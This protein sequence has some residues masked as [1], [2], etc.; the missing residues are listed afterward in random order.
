VSTTNVAITNTIAAMGRLG[1]QLPGTTFESTLTARDVCIDGPADGATRTIGFWRTHLSFLRQVLNTRPLPAAAVNG[2]SPL[3]VASDKVPFTNG[4]L[5]LSTSGKFT[6]GSVADVM[7]VFWSSTAQNSTGKK[8]TTIIC[9]ARITT[10]KQLLGAILNQSFAN[11][12]PLPQVGG[13]DLISA[14]LATMDSGSVTNIRTIGTL[15]DEYNNGGDGTTIVIPG[16]LT[17]GKADPTGARTLAQ[18]KAGDC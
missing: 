18:L 6:M 15:L 9:Q 17:I 1:T 3:G 14:A 7:G 8:R 12:K 13:I 10:G 2:T 16:S 4:S 5:K 11:P